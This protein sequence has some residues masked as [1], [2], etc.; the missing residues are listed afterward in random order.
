MKCAKAG[1]VSLVVGYSLPVHGSARSIGSEGATIADF[2]KVTLHQFQQEAFAIGLEYTLPPLGNSQF[3]Q[4]NRIF[5]SVAT[6]QY[7]STNEEGARII[8]PSH[9]FSF[10]LHQYWFNLGPLLMQQHFTMGRVSAEDGQKLAGETKTTWKNFNFIDLRESVA[11]GFR[12][13]HFFVAF[14]VGLRDNFLP[15][16]PVTIGLTPVPYSIIYPFL[17]I[18]L[19]F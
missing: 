10:G 11:F 14:G 1:I 12:D 7:P 19:Q 17:D 8:L 3:W 4:S 5:A 13:S 16:S 9:E 6:R 2:H 15:E 18:G